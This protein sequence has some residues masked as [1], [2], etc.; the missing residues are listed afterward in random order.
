MAGTQE[1]ISI[2]GMSED[3]EGLMSLGVQEVWLI[4]YLE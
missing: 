4:G 2:K 3:L 1:T